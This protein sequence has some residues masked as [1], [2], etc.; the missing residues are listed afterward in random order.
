[1][2]IGPSRSYGLGMHLGRSENMYVPEASGMLWFLMYCI[3]FL[4][5]GYVA[6]TA[7]L[8]RLSVLFMKE[9]FNRYGEWV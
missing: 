1:M 9:S 2:G 3:P 5:Y 4:I 8:H 6:T 7:F